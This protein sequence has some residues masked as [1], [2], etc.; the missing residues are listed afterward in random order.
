M[1]KFRGV[2]EVERPSGP[3][4]WLPADAVAVL[5][6]AFFDAAACTDWFLER[7]YPDGPRCPRCGFHITGQRAQVRWRELKR[8]TCQSCERKIK[9][10]NGTLLQESHLDPRQ[11]FILLS[12][13]GLG[14]EP[15]AVARVVGVTQTTILNWRDKVIAL[16]EVAQ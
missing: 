9:A 3:V 6:A 10:T 13:L 14:V 7:C 8:I 16:A 12:L 4:T 5:S 15:A 1:S 2:A 11:L